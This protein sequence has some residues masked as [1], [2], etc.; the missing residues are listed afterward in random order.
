MSTTLTSKTTLDP[1]D[2]EMRRCAAMLGWEFPRFLYE[3]TKRYFATM[4]GASGEGY[5]PVRAII[6]DM[7]GFGSKEDA[8]AAA[9]R[10]N[11]YAA[12][13]RTEGET[14]DVFRTTVSGN[15]VRV[16]YDAGNGEWQQPG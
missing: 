7:T 9:E 12:K 3:M 4:D 1:I 14:E 10:F 13:A 8:K 2:T 5:V 6:L 11:A 15:S 16:E